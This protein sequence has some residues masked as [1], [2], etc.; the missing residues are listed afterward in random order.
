MARTKGRQYA[1][2]LA[3]YVERFEQLPPSIM[4]EESRP[5]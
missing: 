4:T 1:L 5:S 2:V 3:E